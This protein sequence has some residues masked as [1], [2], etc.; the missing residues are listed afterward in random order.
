M[1]RGQGELVVADA[2]ERRAKEV[3]T[4][5]P[6]DIGDDTNIVGVGVGWGVKSESFASALSALHFDRGMKRPAQAIQL[7]KRSG[8]VLQFTFRR[9]DDATRRRDATVR[10]LFR[11]SSSS[12][13]VLSVLR[14]VVHLTDPVDPVHYWMSHDMSH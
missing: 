2:R 5:R 14:R 8:R 10:L 7:M 1:T 4:T 12:V 3:E 9:T 11:R 13:R 6:T